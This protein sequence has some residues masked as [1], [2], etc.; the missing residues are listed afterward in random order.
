MKSVSVIYVNYNSTHYLLKSL[1]SLYNR[2]QTQ[3]FSVIIIDNGSQDGFKEQLF[4][5]F[6][7]I[8]I[9]ITN[10]NLGFARACNLGIRQSKSNFIYLLN[11]DTIILNN[12]IEIFTVFMKDENNKDVWSCGG[13]VYNQDN[14]PERSYGEFPTLWD[15]LMEQSGLRGINLKLK[16]LF[17]KKEALTIY[18]NQQNVPFVTGSNLFI[19]R[20][21]LDDIG[22]FNETF[23]L[24][25]EEM[26]LAYRAQK[27]GYNSFVLNG[28]K[29]IHYGSR[30][31]KN[32]KEYL[33]HLRAGQL[34]YFK[35]T[36]PRFYNLLVKSL[37]L[38]GAIMRIIFKLDFIQV[39]RI[40]KI[41]SS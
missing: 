19:R 6:E 37:H 4:S 10:N 15:V 36:K 20:S 39:K 7:D 24:N 2:C 25:C 17:N 41:I 27:S 35:I 28:A 34:N 40:P 8:E 30:S 16:E 1:K 18:K 12:A 32:K 26:E 23:F 38:I 33:N 22:P 3:D 5:R 14:I 9:L 29:I 13:Q 21:V 31:F 11:P